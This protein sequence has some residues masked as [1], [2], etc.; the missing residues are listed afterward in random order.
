MVLFGRIIN[1]FSNNE[2]GAFNSYPNE[3]ILL[4]ISYAIGLVVWVQLTKLFFDS[5]Q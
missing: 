2:F 4:V 3:A 5:K 1:I